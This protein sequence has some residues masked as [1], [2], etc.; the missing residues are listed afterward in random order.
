MG[1][2]F[3]DPLNGIFYNKLVIEMNVSDNYFN[4]IDN[5]YL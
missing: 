2:I 1:K 4:K 5:N 3:I